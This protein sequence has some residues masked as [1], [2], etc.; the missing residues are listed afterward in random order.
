MNQLLL[1][2]K[3]LPDY[4]YKKLIAMADTYMSAL[5]LAINK[6]VTI[7]CG[8]DIITSGLKGAVPWG[9]N[10]KE[11]AFYVEAG[12]TSLQAIQTATAN[13]SL[14]LGKQAPKSS[15]LAEGYDA[16]I[17]T[18]NE[19]P[20]ENINVLGEVDKIINVIKKG[21]IVKGNYFACFLSKK[22]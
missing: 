15:L 4:V 8:T 13:G 11:L 22:S 14:S 6:G 7:A 2:G 10:G 1:V 18:L 12:M 3:S 20:L 19:N 16:D 17:I 21:K 5:Q 9:S